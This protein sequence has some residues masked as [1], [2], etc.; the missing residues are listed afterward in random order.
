M[1]GA[2]LRG[3][4]FD[5]AILGGS[6]LSG[7][8]LEDCSFVGANLSRVDLGSTS[9]RRADFSS[10]D[11]SGARLRDTDCRDS[12]FLRSNLRGVTI[13]RSRFE[14][15]TIGRVALGFTTFVDVDL[16]PFCDVSAADVQAPCV[17][18]WRSICQS[19]KCGGLQRFLERTGMPSV[20]ALY[21]IDC[22]R[23]LDPASIFSMMQ[24]TYK[25]TGSLRTTAP[26]LDPTG[27]RT[28]PG[29]GI[30]HGRSVARID[31]GWRREA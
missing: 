28:S 23:S 12:L 30:G 7:A 8:E 5:D 16:S 14:G 24:T 11:L 29:E 6:S 3:A 18:G 17:V 19:L 31:A 1:A 2:Y 26:A 10:A 4:R 13:E 15:A 21:C 9:V 27:E 25:A 20:F 22:A